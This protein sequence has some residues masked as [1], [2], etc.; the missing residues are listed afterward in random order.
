MGCSTDAAKNS[1]RSRWQAISPSVRWELTGGGSFTWCMP[2]ITLRS[3]HEFLL[4]RNLVKE[5]QVPLEGLL[6]PENGID[7]RRAK[8]RSERNLLD[9]GGF[10]YL[11]G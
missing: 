9:A 5:L 10:E 11:R 2:G 4:V 6:S 7:G 1:A 8:E 3:L